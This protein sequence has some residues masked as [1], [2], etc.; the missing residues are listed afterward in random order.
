MA[1]ESRSGN[2]GLY[3]LVGGLLV[4]VIIMAVIFFNGGFPGMGDRT[5]VTIE[6]PASD[7][8]DSGST[9]SGSATTE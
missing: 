7:G 4:L 5:E 3:F 9:D 6:A 1:E 2:N 8:A